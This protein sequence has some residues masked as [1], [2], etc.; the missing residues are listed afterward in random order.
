[1][2]I[3]EKNNSPKIINGIN[4]IK[5]ISNQFEFTKN[6]DSD[7]ELEDLIFNFFKTFNTYIS[8]NNNPSQKIKFSPEFYE[9]KNDFNIAKI[10]EKKGKLYLKSFNYENE[11]DKFFTQVNRIKE[12]K[13]KTRQSLKNGS[14]VYEIPLY[15]TIN[16]NELNNKLY[17]DIILNNEIKYDVFNSVFFPKNERN[18]NKDSNLIFNLNQ[19]MAHNSKGLLLLEDNSIMNIEDNQINKDNDKNNEKQ[20]HDNDNQEQDSINLDQAPPFFN[21][22]END[23][24]ISKVN[25]KSIYFNEC[26]V[27]LEISKYDNF[28][29]DNISLYLLNLCN[30][31][32][33]PN[34]I[35][36]SSSSKIENI[37]NPDILNL[38]EIINKV[39]NTHLLDLLNHFNNIFTPQIYNKFSFY[40]NIKI[41]NQSIV[42]NDI[43]SIFNE[44]KENS[45]NI[46]KEEESL[47]NDIK[48]YF[49]EELVKEINK[50][51]EITQNFTHFYIEGNKFSKDNMKKIISFLSKEK[52]FMFAWSYNK[53][54]TKKYGLI[55]NVIKVANLSNKVW[56][57]INSKKCQNNSQ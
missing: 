46:E 2:S 36:T 52:Y 34:N 47:M 30:T 48:K 22:K 9:A 31:Q 35:Q 27:M 12:Q 56:F 8:S 18:L 23:T 57:Y 3:N 29:Q 43:N 39:D 5:N 41:N 15:K 38:K 19:K 6:N 21:I 25:S 7:T 55:N 40:K 37:N 14:L 1:M 28:I 49:D 16:L 20:E 4:T 50:D 33:L 45:S 11:F 13:R 42:L 51:L 53:E 24:D 32:N 26:E 10:Y 17:E 44:E 54:E